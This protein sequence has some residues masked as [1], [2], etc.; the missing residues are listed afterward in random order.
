MIKLTHLSLMLSSS[1]PHPQNLF[2]NPFILMNSSLLKAVTPP[3]N[4]GNLTLKLYIYIIYTYK[5]YL[6]KY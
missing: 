3:N 1:P 2:E 5:I 6:Y 4:F